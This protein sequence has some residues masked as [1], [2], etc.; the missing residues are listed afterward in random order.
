MTTTT[1]EIEYWRSKQTKLW[2]KMKADLFEGAIGV[3][4]VEYVFTRNITEATPRGFK[5]PESI[6][7]KVEPVRVRVTTRMEILEAGRF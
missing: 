4:K 3:T 6:R 1:K 5:I 7:K 2:L